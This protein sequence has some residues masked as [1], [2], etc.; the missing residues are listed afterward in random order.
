MARVKYL[1]QSDLAP[2][3][4]ELLARSANFFRA[5]VHSPE[6]YRSFGQLGGWI[7]NTSTLDSRLREMAI[8]QVGYMTSCEYEYSHHIK[9]G[10]DF[11][12][13]DDDIR[14]IAADTAGK[15]TALSELDCA[16]LQLTREMTTDIQGSQ[17]AFDAVSAELG[18]EHTVDLLLVI[19]FYNAVVRMLYTLEIDVEDEYLPLLEEFPLPPA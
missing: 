1:D 18:E 10:R 12:V 3:D 4:Q 17:E 13:S 15:A 11:G 6:A 5:F 7:R 8:L 19:S 9:I 16:V 2:E 14:A